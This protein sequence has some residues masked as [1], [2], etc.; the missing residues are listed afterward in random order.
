MRAVANN[1]DMELAL[2]VFIGIVTVGLLLFVAQ[3]LNEIRE[4]LRGL[5][6]E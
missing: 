6:S 3:C 5:R 4:T 2:L 1:M